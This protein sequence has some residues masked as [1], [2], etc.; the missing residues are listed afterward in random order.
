[1][2][3]LPCLAFKVAQPADGPECKHLIPSC[4]RMLSLAAE[5]HLSTKP[6]SIKGYLGAVPLHQLPKVVNLPQSTSAQTRKLAGSST[7]VLDNFRQMQPL[8]LDGGGSFALGSTSR[9]REWGW[10]FQERGGAFWVQNGR[11][12]GHGKGWDWW[13]QHRPNSN[14]RPSL[15]VLRGRFPHNM[16]P[17]LLFRVALVRF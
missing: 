11:W 2:P 10:M 4:T 7:G 1:M 16:H 3:C 17:E 15:A 9:G 5:M 8:A 13:L 6:F 14:P 12:I